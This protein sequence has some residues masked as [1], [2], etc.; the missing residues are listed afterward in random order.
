MTN[1]ILSVILVLNVAV[2]LSF[3]KQL[4]DLKQQVT[5]LEIKKMTR[6]EIDLKTKVIAKEM[7]TKAKAVLSIRC[8]DSSKPPLD[9]K[10]RKKDKNAYPKK[11]HGTAAKVGYNY[12]LT[13]DHLISNSGDETDRVLPIKC[14]LYQRG[15]EVGEYNSEVH[16]FK[17]VGQKDIALIEVKFNSEGE[18]ISE[19]VPEVYPNLDVGETLVLITH[20]RNMINDYLITFGLVLNADAEKILETKRKNYWK[21]AIITDMMAAPGSSGSPVLSLDGKFIGIH[22]GGDRDEMLNANYQIM[23]DTEFYLSYQM[24]K[25]FHAKNNKKSKGK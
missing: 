19:L 24:Y 4:N 12:L 21:N 3:N 16:K 23:F 11:W 13:V 20:P 14:L 1:K 6:Q 10:D 5:R 22:V 2:I 7:K 17:Q 9:P 25:L 8:E 15:V 18:D